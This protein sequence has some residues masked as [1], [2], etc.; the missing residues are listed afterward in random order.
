M[1]DL[2]FSDYGRSSRFVP[3]WWIIPG[4]VVAAVFWLALVT[5]AYS[6]VPAPL[7][8][9]ELQALQARV[10]N[11][12]SNN[13]QCNATAIALQRAPNRGRAAHVAF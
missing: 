1:R 9:P 7:V 4:F 10:L 8:S 13:L 6:Q 5:Y 3:G 11:E 12:V 2:E